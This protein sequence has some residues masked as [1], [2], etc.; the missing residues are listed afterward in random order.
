M[1]VFFDRVLVMTDLLGRSSLRVQL[2]DVVA[3]NFS[4]CG[5]NFPLQRAIHA[6]R[7]Q[8]PRTDVFLRAE[9]GT[10]NHIVGR[11]VFE[12]LE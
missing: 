4:A 9:C 10:L 1:D 2:G 8:P 6:G 11:T 7:G 12:R 5:F 3:D